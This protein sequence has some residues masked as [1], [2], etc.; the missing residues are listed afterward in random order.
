VKIRELRSENIKRLSVVAIKPDGNLVEITGKN[1]QGKSSV[2]DSIWFALAGKGAI[3]K[4]PIRKGQQTANIKLDLG[5]FVVTRTFSRI[6]N[7]APG[8]DEYTTKVTL[9]T[10]EGADMRKPQVILDGLLGA[11]CF[12]PLEFARMDGK[13]QFNALRGMVPDFDFEKVEGQQRTDHTARLE[14]GRARDQAKAAAAVIDVPEGVPAEEIDEAA[15]SKKLADAAKH[16]GDIETRKANRAT[17]AERVKVMRQDAQNIR[18]QAATLEDEAKEQADK[19]MAEAQERCRKLHEDAIA[20]AGN[21][22][23][24][25]ARMSASADE[26]QKKIDEA[27]ALPEPIDVDQVAAAVDAARVTNAQVRRKR[28]KA[29]HLARHEE[30][31]KLWDEIDARMKARETAKQKAIAAAKFPVEGLGFGD[32]VILLNGLPFE[33]A[34]DAERLRV[35]CAIAMASNPKL[36]VI[37]VR[38]GS[39]LDG[40]AMKLLAEMADAHDMQ[41][42]IETVD[43]R[44]RAAVVLEDGHVKEAE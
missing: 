11:I 16:N 34:S 37:R 21:L 10:A 2:L 42:W 22:E 29:A 33:Q 39:L 43:A 28:E 41:V 18:A 20:R 9:T 4:Q 40:D 30:Q 35:S 23:D 38:D 24:S 8:E 6:D 3:Q 7:A 5:D 15:L 14:A 13:A 19:I 25:A 27:E 36:R 1:G 44:G 31:S 26:L 12:D 32:G 17:A